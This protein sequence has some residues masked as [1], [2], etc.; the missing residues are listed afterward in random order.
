MALNNVVLPAPFGPIR[1]TI[2][3]GSTVRSTASSATSPPK[4]SVTR[5]TSRRWG[6]VESDR[7]M[8][9][10]LF[11]VG[12]DQ[13][14]AQPRRTHHPGGDEGRAHEQQRPRDDEGQ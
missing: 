12:A 2:S 4:R 10:C 5:S 14:E 11:D 1:P 6:L 7:V 13:R 9:G 3:P 8:A